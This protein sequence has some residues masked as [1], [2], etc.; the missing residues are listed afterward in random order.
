MASKWQLTFGDQLISS[1]TK[2]SKTS[3]YLQKIDQIV[4]WQPIVEEVGRVNKT[5]KSRGGRPRH[6]LQWMIKAIFLQHLFNLSDPE[7]EDQLIDRISFQRFVGITMDHEIPD[8]SSFW[9]FKEALNDHQLAGK[10][11]DLINQQLDDHGLMVKKGTIVDAKIIESSGRPLSDKKRQELADEPS[12]QIDTDAHSTKKG[13]TWYFGYIGHIGVDC[14]SKLIRKFEFTPANVD[15]G[16]Q[17]EKLV[18]YDEG[19]L[20]GDKAYFDY[21]HQYSARQLGW[22]YGVLYKPDRGE[23]LSRS[24]QKKN[25]K[26]S[27]VR[28]AVE[29]PFGW[30]VDKA[31]LTTMKA[32]TLA[33]NSTRFAFNCIGYN[34]A[35]AVYLKRKQNPAG[36]VAS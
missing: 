36:V 23:V 22:Y 26:W 3:S 27:R 5:S 31:N 14:G 33:R 13:G 6:Q 35:R 30:M 15:D 18:S 24:Q 29:H 10:I 34:L 1:R 9:R 25:K 16:T 21:H 8:H 12:C 32:K 28:A 4:D 20:F 17:T 11:F 7:L 19:A 2:Q